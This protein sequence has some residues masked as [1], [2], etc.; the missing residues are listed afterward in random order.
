MAKRKTTKRKCKRVS[1]AKARFSSGKK[2][3]K[4]KPGC[5]YLKGDGAQCCTGPKK[6]KGRKKKAGKKKRKRTGAAKRARKGVKPHTPKMDVLNAWRRRWKA[7]RSCGGKKAALQKI[8]VQFKHMQHFKPSKGGEPARARRWNRWMREYHNKVAQTSAFCG[9]PLR[10]ASGSRT[11][12]GRSPFP[13]A[14]DGIGG[15]PCASP[16]PPRWCNK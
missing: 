11:T 6:G 3:G 2:K 14:T 7:D 10:P 1:R 8:F 13:R 5:R 9:R 16:N 4:L 15:H 12:S